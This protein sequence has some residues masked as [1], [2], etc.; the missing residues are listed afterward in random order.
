MR[1][2]TIITP[3]PTGRP[4]P[5]RLVPAPRGTKEMPISLQSFTT[6][7]TSAVDLRKDGHARA[8]LF[9]DERVALVNGEVGLRIEHVVG[10]DNS[11]KT[12]GDSSGVD[13]GHV[14]TDDSTGT[15]EY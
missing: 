8:M 10:A 2:R 9:D 5:A 1:V 13:R 3:P 15:T 11:A 14:V 12:V 6:A 4:P 7:A